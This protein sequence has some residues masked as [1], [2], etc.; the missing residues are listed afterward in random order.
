[1]IA[2]VRPSPVGLLHL[3]HA[4]LWQYWWPTTTLASQVQWHDV[5]EQ[6]IGGWFLDS[7]P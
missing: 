2:S 5:L 4:L 7:L 3:Q 6:L 1:L